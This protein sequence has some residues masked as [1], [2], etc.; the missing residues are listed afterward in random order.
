[1]KIEP[2]I[3]RKHANRRLYDTARKRYLSL[4]QAVTIA[5]RLGVRKL[6]LEGVD[7][8]GVG[9]LEVYVRAL[10]ELGE[11]RVTPLL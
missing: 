7:G 8:S 1:M 10:T 9:D 6:T 11:R 4:D 3:I 2:R 5:R